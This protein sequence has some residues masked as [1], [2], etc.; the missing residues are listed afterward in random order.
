MNKQKEMVRINE[1]T[2][3]CPYLNEQYYVAVKPICQVLGLNHAAQTRRINEDQFLSSVVAHIATTGSD[4]KQYKMLCIPLKYVFGWL[5][6][7]DAHKVK[8]T[9]KAALERYKVEC[10]DVLYEHFYMRAAKYEKRERLK[11]EKRESILIAEQQR[12]DAVAKV[13]KLKREL[14]ELDEAP[15]AQISMLDNPDFL[16][17]KNQNHANHPTNS[18]DT[19][20]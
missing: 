7:I 11:A 8:P 5:F 1:V 2:I 19:A 14:K 4:Q 12:K 6:Q 16:N 15:I 17:E 13:D 18:L 3:E 10:Y 20:D 9:A